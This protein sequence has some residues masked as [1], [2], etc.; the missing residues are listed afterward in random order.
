MPN[1]QSHANVGV[2]TKDTIKFAESERKRKHD[3]SGCHRNQT[4]LTLLHGRKNCV[5]SLNLCSSLLNRQTSPCPQHIQRCITLSKLRQLAPRAQEQLHVDNEHLFNRVEDCRMFL[6]GSD[7]KRFLGVWSLKD[8]FTER[9]QRG[10]F[11][12]VDTR[13]ENGR[14]NLQRYRPDVALFPTGRVTGLCW[15]PNSQSEH[16]FLYTSTC[17]IGNNKP[18]IVYLRDDRLKEKADFN[19]GKRALWCCAWNR[20]GAQ[21]SVG[22]DRSSLVL[23][24]VTRRMW[25]VTSR[26]STV[27]TQVFSQQASTPCTLYR[28]FS[29]QKNNLAV[30]VSG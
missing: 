24:T 5:Q 22:T 14:Y 18:S 10:C 27:F 3:L 17:F 6:L 28:E 9:L 7:S 25:E 23:D 26:G 19:L 12:P 21:F 30:S 16:D 8:T 20:P 11:H 4:T 29:D 2:V 13:D 1:H 15:A